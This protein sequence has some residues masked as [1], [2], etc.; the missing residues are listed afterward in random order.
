MYAKGTNI[1]PEVFFDSMNELRKLDTD[2]L[3][4]I[5]LLKV[6]FA[7]FLS[8]VDEWPLL[9]LCHRIFSLAFTT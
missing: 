2:Y 7:I 4:I 5:E 9:T 3:P 1:V 6:R 8:A